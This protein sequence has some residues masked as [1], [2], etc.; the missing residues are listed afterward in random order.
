MGE[1]GSVVPMV[2]AV[3]SS[4]LPPVVNSGSSSSG[5]S[6]LSVDGRESLHLAWKKMK[7]RA[8]IPALLNDLGLV[9]ESVEVEVGVRKG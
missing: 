5:A 8:A 4:D 3:A 9:G 7:D 6:K 1:A 2:P